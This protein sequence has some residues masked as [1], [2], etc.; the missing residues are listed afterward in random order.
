MS[1]ISLMRAL[2]DP[3]S[4][5]Y[6]E[7]VRN[8]SATLDCG[9]TTV[10]DA[11]GADLG[12]QRAVADGLIDG[13]RL[14]IAI[15]ILSQ[16]AGHGDGWLPSGIVLD[17]PDP[18]RPSGIVD[19]PDEMRKRVRELVRAGANVIKVCTSGGVLSPGDS[20]Q[21]AHFPPRLSYSGLRPIP[22]RSRRASALTS[23]WPMGTRSTLPA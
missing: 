7:A 1:A 13:P 9:I 18:G 21:H 15:T 12:I 5:Q 4:Y 8:L 14:R 19:G 16:T 20:P 2:Q 22:G 3:F 23:S 11:G 17:V 10:R 6:F